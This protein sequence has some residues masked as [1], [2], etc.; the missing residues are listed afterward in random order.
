MTVKGRE[1]SS[2]ILGTE[3]WEVKQRIYILL[4]TK[5]KMSDIKVEIGNLKTDG[6]GGGLKRETGK[7]IYSYPAGRRQ[8]NY[9]RWFKYDRD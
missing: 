1:D 4:Y 5:G 9:T 8:E 2:F 6:G 7:G 3:K